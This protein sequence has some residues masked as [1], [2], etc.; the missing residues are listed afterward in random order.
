MK[1]LSTSVKTNISVEESFMTLAKM[2]YEYEARQVVQR[3]ETMYLGKGDV[4]NKN[5]KGCCW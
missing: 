1:H 2:V 5:K 4:K 3:T